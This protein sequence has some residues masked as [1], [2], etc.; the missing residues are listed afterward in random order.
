LIN[1]EI[2]NKLNQDKAYD[3]YKQRFANPADFTFV[4]VGP[5]VIDSIKPFILTYLGGLKT[6]KEKE[7]WKDNNVRHPKGEIVK[8]FERP[9][10]VEK[11]SVNLSYWGELP[12]S[13]MNKVNLDALADVLKIRC[14]ESIRE[15]KGGT[16]SIGVSG[17]VS[18]KP[19]SQGTLSIRFDT[20]KEKADTLIGIAQAELDKIQKEGVQTVDLDK[21]KAAMLKRFEENSKGKSWWVTVIKTYEEEGI[22]LQTDYEKAINNLTSESIQQT[23]IA[24]LAQ[25]NRIEF[26]MDPKKDTN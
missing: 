20:N 6:T 2:I 26:K 24:L 10:Q 7:T 19:I 14:R 15:D 11:T 21:V 3:I 5:F 13:M 1:K 12:Y 17:K 4:L 8:H 23:L 9:M 25:K 16:Y 18:N 22:N